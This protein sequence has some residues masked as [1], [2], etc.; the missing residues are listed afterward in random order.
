MQTLNQHFYIS[1]RSPATL[2]V[3]SKKIICP[4][5]PKS[6]EEMVYQHSVKG[7]LVLSL[8]NGEMKES[9]AEIIKNKLLI[10]LY[11]NFKDSCLEF[12]EKTKD[13]L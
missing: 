12:A 8:Q 2:Q 11:F 4:L 10:F 1:K 5:P 6:L 7:F 9:S 13:D 3:F